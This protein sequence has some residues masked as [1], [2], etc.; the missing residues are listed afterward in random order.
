MASGE[1]NA[2]PNDGPENQW[3][4]YELLWGTLQHY[5]DRWVDSYRV[6]LSFNAFLL[7]AVTAL[8]GFS[9]KENSEALRPFVS[10]LC[11]IGVWSTWQGIGLLKRIRIDTDLRLNQLTRL[12]DKMVDMPVRPFKEGKNFF[13]HNKDVEGFLQHQHRDK[14]RRAIDAYINS[15]WA[16]NGYYLIVGV[17]ALFPWFSSVCAK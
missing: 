15:S 5:H 4:L 16:I 1:S 11:G 8:L 6:F 3:K 7:P 13:F 17:Y 10:L 9:F 12:E 2:P 14:G